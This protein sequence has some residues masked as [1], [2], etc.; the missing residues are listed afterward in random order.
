MKKILPGNPTP[1]P[2]YA[3]IQGI[4]VGTMAAFSVVMIVIGPEY[5]LRLAIPVLY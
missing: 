3:T 1:V 2:D 5:V 4:L